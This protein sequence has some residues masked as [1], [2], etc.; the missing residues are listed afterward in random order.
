[1]L[2]QLN[3]V[4]LQATKLRVRAYWNHH[5]HS[6]IESQYSVFSLN[7]RR[8]LRWVRVADSPRTRTRTDKTKCEGKKLLFLCHRQNCLLLRFQ[9]ISVGRYVSLHKH[10]FF[11]FPSKWEEEKNT[12]KRRIS[13][14]H[15]SL[16]SWE[17][18]QVD[19]PINIGQCAEF[20]RVLVNGS[21][22]L[23]LMLTKS[24][25]LAQAGLREIVKK[26][27]IA[28]TRCFCVRS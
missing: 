10:T 9:S 3:G 20:L 8:C 5:R 11:A 18:A 14:F 1:M 19:H 23:L 7:H 27:R 24:R 6:R 26:S 2:L 17:L 16:C 13:S 25:Q 4:N 28:Q 15:I 22:L 21:L 12:P